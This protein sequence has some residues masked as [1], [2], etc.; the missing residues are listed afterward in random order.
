MAGRR[1]GK[2][3]N[4]AGQVRLIEVAVL[5]GERR[6]RFSRLLLHTMERRLESDDVRETLCAVADPQSHQSIEVPGTDAA[7][8][9][10]VDNRQLSMFTLD[11][12]NRGMYDAVYGRISK[13]ID[14][15]PFKRRDVL[16][17]RLRP[18][19]GAREFPACRNVT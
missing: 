16:L 8:S 1:T 2:S 14:Q 5:V 17:G 7:A 13:P 10:E 18:T 11:L 9:G 3:R 4:G 19:R 15:E 12:L 6:R